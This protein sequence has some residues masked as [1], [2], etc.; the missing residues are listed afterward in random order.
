MP[1]A[2]QHDTGRR[3]PP[4]V[5][6]AWARPAADVLRELDV[7]P[8]A[9]LGEQE[10]TARRERCGRNALLQV[11]SRSPARILLE[12]FKSVVI[13]LLVVAGV[14]ALIF[15]RLAEAV[16]IAAVLFV[17]AGIGFVSEW[18]AVRSVEAL[19]RLGKPRSRVRRDGRERQIPDDEVVCGDVIL[20]EA[21]DVVEADLRLLEANNLQ[22]DESVLTGESVSVRKQVDPVE[23][24]APLAERASM[25][26]RGTTVTEGSGEAVVVAVGMA[27]ELGRISELAQVVEEERTPLEQRLAWLGRRLAWTT[28]AIAVA[29]GVSGV[30]AGR[31]VLLV[32]ETAIALGV[33]AIPEGLPIVANLALARGMWLMSRRQALIN[34]LPAVETLGATRVIFTDKTGTLT[35]NRMALQ[36]V[37]TAAGAWEIGEDSRSSDEQALVR[38]V[39]EVGVLCNNASLTGGDEE[40]QQA[41]GDPTEVAL[42]RA[43]AEQGLDRKELL[44]R[45]P[46]EREVSFDPGT[47][48]MGTFHAS[49]GGFDV[50][51]KGAPTAVLSA[52]DR[53]AAPDG[54]DR[55]LDDDARDRWNRKGQE[56]AEAGLRVLAAA[57]KHVDSA[58]AD[59]YEGLRFLGLFGL[60]DPPREGV[61]DLID[62][63]EK[64][65]IRVVMVTGD[66]PGTARA[67]G[68][69]IGLCDDGADEPVL[70]GRELVAPDALSDEQRHRVLQTRVFARVSPEQK[71]HL[72]SIFQDAGETVAMTGDGVN[73][74]PALRKADIGIAMGR[75]GTD[76]AREV[77]DMVLK[78]DAFGSIV[79]AVE[80]G[81]IIF[82]NIRKS[83]LFMLCTNVAEIIAVA[84]ASL[85]D[86]PLPLRPLQILYL[87]VV[88]DVFPAL[89][90]GVGP[91][92]P[93]VMRR[94]PRD[95]DEPVLTRRHWLSVAAWGVLIA[96]C[97]LAGLQAAR[98]WLGVDELGA[99]T[100]S[101][102]TL[103]LA[104]LWFVLNLRDPGSGLLRNDIVRNKWIWG[105]IGLCGALLAAA[106]YLPGLSNVLQT[107]PLGPRGWAIALTVSTVPLIVGQAIRET[108]RLR[109]GGR[110]VRQG[111][112]LSR[113]A[114]LRRGHR[115]R[116]R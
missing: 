42:L 40:Q 94:P 45:A 113:S 74:A 83:V 76:A 52:C 72:V 5:E 95:S 68:R 110:P 23:E 22:V 56:L 92:S 12:Q 48:M 73:D 59:P 107:R 112:R 71:L 20:I 67:I 2:K 96:A 64:A 84:V 63:C 80:Q 6:S 69:Q 19:R 43:G 93:E 99:V 35:E 60:L 65:G 111:A 85:A 3:N 47:M 108:Q 89:A 37:V 31:E 114:G 32:I 16:A 102:L 77:S 10:T 8:Q 116:A 81:R 62:A 30:L 44:A 41:Q 105:A 9:G 36:R 13:G 97:V 26:W 17:N 51:V 58:D 78:D 86:L 49:D 106:T 14:L 79:A 24:D 70:H 15:G 90:L 25:L 103:A 7:N 27:T 53:L 34:R 39:L 50:A 100:V 75:R 11:R 38:R 28:I 115:E 101:F 55:V 88:T 4:A 87:N 33:A 57:E 1:K 82:G 98:W 61:G 104:K 29:V 46:E 54:E 91:G 18:R 66:Q 21:G 109:Q